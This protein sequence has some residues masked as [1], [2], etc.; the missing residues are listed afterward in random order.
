MAENRA[1]KRGH[2]PLKLI[3][4]CSV[5]GALV[6]AL[7]LVSFSFLLTFTGSAS[8]SGGTAG[9]VSRDAWMHRC[10]FSLR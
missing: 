6:L 4:F 10:R 9:T 5:V 1:E 3:L 2:I 8:R 7:L